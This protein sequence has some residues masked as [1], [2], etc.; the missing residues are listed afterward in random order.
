MEDN[1]VTYDE[2]LKKAQELGIT[3]T[4]T[5]LDVEGWDT[6]SKLIILT[7]VLMKENKAVRFTS[8]ILGDL[9][10]LSGA[11]GVMPAA[12]SILRDLINILRGYKFCR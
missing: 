12:A 11:S 6:A 3:E 7:N 9:T 10:I 5:T 4:D 1:A 2:A 8:D